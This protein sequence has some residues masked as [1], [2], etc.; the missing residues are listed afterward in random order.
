VI[1]IAAGHA[2][3]GGGGDDAHDQ[4]DAAIDAPDA[5][6]DGG[7]LC[8]P[9]L[10][11]WYHFDDTSG[12]VLDACG[13]HDGSAEGTG[14][15]RGAAGRIGSAFAFDGTDG[16][17]VVPAARELDFVTSGTIELWIKI[18]DKL[19]PGATVSRGTG[20]ADDNVL[21]T[22]DCG[23]VLTIYTQVP[24]GAAVLASECDALTEASWA[25]VAVVNDGTQARLYIN[26]QLTKTSPGGFLGTLPHALYIGRRQQGE[27]PLT[28]SLD[29]LMWWTVVRTQEQ[30]CGDAIG[31]WAGDHCTL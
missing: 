6:P 26:A 30:I 15:T 13:H 11:A 28:G 10:A 3:C 12:P 19:N 8:S 9:G 17:V 24:D 29:E 21:Q 18:A 5:S 31:T 22:T 27:F 14:V 4:M 7:S 1:A 2:G 23:N 25:H 20:N 16:R